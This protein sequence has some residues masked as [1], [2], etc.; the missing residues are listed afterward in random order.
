MSHNKTKAGIM[1][2]KWGKTNI[3]K[4]KQGMLNT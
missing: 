1:N 3:C 4:P 2:E